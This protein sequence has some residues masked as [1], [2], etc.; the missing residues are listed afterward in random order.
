MAIDRI[1]PDLEEGDELIPVTR[2]TSRGGNE[3][4]PEMNDSP[5]Q[6]IG[7]DEAVKGRPLTAEERNR[8]K[9]ES[10]LSD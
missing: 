7:Y 1:E 9:R 3:P 4:P 8:A 5:E 10:P 2:E 6:N